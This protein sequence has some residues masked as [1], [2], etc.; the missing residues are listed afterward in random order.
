MSKSIQF[1]IANTPDQVEEAFQ[2][3]IHLRPHLTRVGFRD[4]FEKMKQHGYHIIGLWADQ[5]LVCLAGVE[6][7]HNF[8]NGTHLYV[9]DLV[10]DT[11]QRS[12]QYGSQMM[13]YLEEYAC[14]LDCQLI[15]LESGL[16]RIHAHRF[17]EQ[18]V[19]MS[20][21][22]FSYRKDLKR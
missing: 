17:Y 19:G 18:K 14:T 6:V 22:S 3:L 5:K 16:E 20:K 21:A 10:T 8:Y 13:E 4:L 12:Q 1:Q 7:K 11:T 2:L 9:Y 15:A